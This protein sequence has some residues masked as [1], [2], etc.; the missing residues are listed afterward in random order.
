MRE[1]AVIQRHTAKLRVLQ[2]VILQVCRTTPPVANDEYQRITEFFLPDSA[3]PKTGLNPARERLEG[4]IK[5]NGNCLE[6]AGPL[7][8]PRVLAE[9]QRELRNITGLQQMRR[10]L[11]KSFAVH[12]AC[13][14]FV[15]GSGATSVVVF[16][17]RR[18]S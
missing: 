13:E 4:D 7:K 1:Q 10:Q 3:L 2:Q 9:K 17:G 16:C 12:G 11:G 14:S 8:F 6:G 15:V 18:R 5:G